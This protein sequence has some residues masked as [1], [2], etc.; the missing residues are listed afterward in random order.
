[1]TEEEADRFCEERCTFLDYKDISEYI[2]DIVTCLVYSSWNYTEQQARE[3]CE[4]RKL[5]IERYF[6]DKVPADDAAADVGYCG[7]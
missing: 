3:Q 1:M 5:F 6:K 2:E 7:G 4:E